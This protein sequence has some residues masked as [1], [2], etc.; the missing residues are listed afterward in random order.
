MKVT[1]KYN[2]L[3]QWLD[4]E[5]GIFSLLQQVSVKSWIPWFSWSQH[6]PVRT[7]LRT[8]PGYLFYV[9]RL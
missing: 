8:W 4:S 9:L 6:E 2:P 3:Y 1:C 7:W 5:L